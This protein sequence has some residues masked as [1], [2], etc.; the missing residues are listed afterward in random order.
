[1]AR[2]GLGPLTPYHPPTLQ[3]LKEYNVNRPGQVEVIWQPL[4]EIQAYP[5][6]GVAQITFF[7]NTVG[8]GGLTQADTNMEA[9]GQMPRPKEFLVVGIQVFFE[10]G[11]A[12]AVGNAAAATTQE[13]WND[14]SD[15][16]NGAAF[17]RFFIGSKD[18]LVDAPLSKF[19]QQF[20]LGGVA[21]NAATGTNATPVVWLIDYAVHSGRYYSITPTK[22]PSNQNFNV[23][24]NF[25][26]VIAVNVAGRVGVILD[27]FQYRLSQ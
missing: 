4:Y 14:V 25:P 5:I 8:A 27:G 9:A 24:L 7:Q 23:S 15:V 16:M 18:Y 17:L 22:L 21:N 11:N 1:M 19:T 6:A 3:A 26:V 10:P 12:I 13:N 2:H 20:R